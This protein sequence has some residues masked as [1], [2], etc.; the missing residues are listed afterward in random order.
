MINFATTRYYPHCNEEITLFLASNP[1][2]KTEDLL[3]GWSSVFE[4][5]HRDDS[6]TLSPTG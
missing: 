4:A 5:W 3:W 2:K 1:H 6:A